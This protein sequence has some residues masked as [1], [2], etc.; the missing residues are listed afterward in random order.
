MMRGPGRALVWALLAFATADARAQN[1]VELLQRQRLEA[2]A[3]EVAAGLDPDVAPRPVISL[4]AADPFT[5]AFLAVQARRQAVLDSVAAERAAQTRRDS[6]AGTPPRLVWA[7][8]EPDAQGAF[9]DRYR[10]VFWRASDP[11]RLALDT[12]ATPVIRGRLQN[13]FGRPTRNADALR[14]VGYTGNEF[15]Q[16]EYWFVVNDSI[17]VLLLDLDGPFGRGLLL[18][19]SEE[20]ADALPD[21]KADLSRQLFAAPGP[22]PF[23]DYY[24]SFERESWYRTGF[25]GTEF[26]TVPIRPPGWVQSR[27]VDRWVIH[28]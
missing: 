19:G 25:N 27:A 6:L 26:F 18:A 10:E 13:V 23:V 11:R 16:F 8:V 24:H 22:D 12:T 28:R 14:Q 9:L 2:R 1:V 3:A 4:G 7:K 15:V 5:E 20:F 17:P 21:L